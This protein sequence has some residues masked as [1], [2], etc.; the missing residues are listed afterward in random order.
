MCLL[1]ETALAASAWLQRQGAATPYA[2]LRQPSSLT[3]VIRRAH[4]AHSEVLLPPAKHPL[5]PCKGKLRISLP[6]E[7]HSQQA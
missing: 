2:Q 3:P 6:R 4:A 1:Q 5:Y 7:A